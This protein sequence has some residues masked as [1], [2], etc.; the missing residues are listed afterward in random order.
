[1]FSS[2]AIDTFTPYLFFNF[3]SIFSYY[4]KPF[5]NIILK[6]YIERVY[7]NFFNHV[8][9]SGDKHSSVMRIFRHKVFPHI[10][11]VFFRPHEDD[12]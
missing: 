1:M 10:E 4:F 6:V 3:L 11:H 9:N 5:I 12:R 7:H 8:F 2:L